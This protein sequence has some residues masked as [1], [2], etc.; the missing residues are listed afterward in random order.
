MTLTQGEILQATKERLESGRTEKS[1]QWIAERKANAALAWYQFVSYHCQKRDTRG[2]IAYPYHQCI[3]NTKIMEAWCAEQVPPVVS[4]INLEQ[5]YEQLI[6][7]GQLAKA[8]ASNAAYVKK[9]LPRQP[10]TPQRV[11]MAPPPVTCEMTPSEIRSL[12][13]SQLRRLMSRPGMEAAI[14]KVLQEDRRY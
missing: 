11:E 10:Y 6:A 2:G 7:S 13:A 3:S 12:S 4:R 5:A 1:E 8:P 9:T 14:D